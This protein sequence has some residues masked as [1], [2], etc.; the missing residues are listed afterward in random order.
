MHF[1]GIATF[2]LEQT[3]KRYVIFP[4]LGVFLGGL[5]HGG[6]AGEKRD[7]R[8]KESERAWAWGDIGGRTREGWRKIKESSREKEK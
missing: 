7:G 1:F 5:S 2:L 8:A 6:R 3:P 4:T